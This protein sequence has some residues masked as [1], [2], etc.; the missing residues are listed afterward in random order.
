MSDEKKEV[1]T[2]ADALQAS[3]A[4]YDEKDLRTGLRKVSRVRRVQLM[5]GGHTVT[6]C[7]GHPVPILVPRQGL[8]CECQYLW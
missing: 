6:T 7:I 8:A 3:D 1:G 2:T 5:S 4:I